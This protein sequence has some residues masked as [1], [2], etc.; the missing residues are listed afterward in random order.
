MVTPEAL[1]AF[2]TLVEEHQRIQHERNGYNFSPP[3]VTVTRG[4]RWHKV[5]VG[6]SGKY[7]VEATTGEILGIKG[8]GVPHH[9]HRYGTLETIDRYDWGGYAPV[10]LT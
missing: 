10:A 1:E 5:D 2:R 7:V 4:R 3:A 9:G 6:D 8:Y